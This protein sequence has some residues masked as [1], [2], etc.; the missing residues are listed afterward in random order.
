MFEI[1]SENSTLITTIVLIGFA[2]WI[3][4]RVITRPSEPVE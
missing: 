3:A 4:A 2:L 1:I